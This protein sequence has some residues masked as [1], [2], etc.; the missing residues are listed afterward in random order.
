MSDKI[1]AP[2][3]YLYAF[4]LH[5]DGKG[6]NNPLWKHC[7]KILANFTDQR[8][9]PNLVFPQDSRSYREDLL[10]NVYLEFNSNPPIEGFADR[11]SVV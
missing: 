8:V 9:T 2:N 10:P 7:D 1:S 3:V 11:K 4:Q 5:N 6:S